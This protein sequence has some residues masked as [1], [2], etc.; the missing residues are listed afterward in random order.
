LVYNARA[1]EDTLIST[2]VFQQMLKI[3]PGV[4]TGPSVS[5]AQVEQDLIMSLRS[6]AREKP[7]LKQRH[8]TPAGTARPGNGQDGA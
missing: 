4:K 6:L 3:A 8:V 7:L 1:E 2:V 5:D